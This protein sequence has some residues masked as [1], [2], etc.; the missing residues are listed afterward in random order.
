MRSV[1]LTLEAEELAFR[2]PT[3]RG[4]SSHF[5]S[6]AAVATVTWHAS[7]CR[8]WNMEFFRLSQVPNKNSKH[9]TFGSLPIGEIEFL[10]NAGSRAEAAEETYLYHLNRPSLDI[11][12]VIT[13]WDN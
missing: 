4:R 3:G 2:Y 13:F 10:T 12:A 7:D 1:P 11:A 5:F 6:A 8:T 9:V